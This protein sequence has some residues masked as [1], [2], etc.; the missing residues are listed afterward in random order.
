M[1]TKQYHF[2]DNQWLDCLSPKPDNLAN[3]VWV[4]SAKS[5]VHINDISY[6]VLSNIYPNAHIVISTSAGEIYSDLV[7]EH[8]ICVN[9]ITFDKATIRTVSKTIDRH[10]QED[11]A[12]QLTQ[13]LLADDLQFVFILSDGLIT[14][15]H[16][17]LAGVNKVL[18]KNVH[19]SGGMSGDDG[20]FKETL[21]GLNQAPKPNQLVIIG[22][23]GKT[24]K[25]SSSAESGK[26]PF[27]K[28]RKITQ[29]KENIIY[30]IDNEPALELYK[31][32]LGDLSK[33]LPASGLSYPLQVQDKDNN[34][35]LIRSLLDVDWQNGSITLAG[36]VPANSELYLMHANNQNL[37]EGAST[38]IKRCIESFND[39]PQL[40]IVVSC[41]G[42]KNAMKKWIEDELTPIR[43]EIGDTQMIGFYSY[44]EFA[45]HQTHQECQ[46]FNET[47][48]VTILKEY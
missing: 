39:Q 37:V 13:E 45:S 29:S 22:F 3:L 44:G 11:I 42:R 34:R 46:L 9:V 14:N 15:G 32:Y 12:Q 28:K 30:T 48:C 41:V 19:A 24:L 26:N 10:N 16:A 20:L 7:Y 27:G 8:S 47:L 40:A 4:I 18:P 1:N 21:I 2:S 5:L 33:D 36:N 25:V 17:L 6:K 23:Y 35:W 38:A 31:R 43:N